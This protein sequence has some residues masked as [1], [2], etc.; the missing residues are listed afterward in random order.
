MYLITFFLNLGPIFELQRQ[1]DAL[2]LN[3]GDAMFVEAIITDSNSAGWNKRAVKP[4]HR[5]IYINGGA[6][7]P[8]CLKRF[9]FRPLKRLACLH[10]IGINLL[11][12]LNNNGLEC[13]ADIICEATTTGDQMAVFVLPENVPNQCREIV[14]DIFRDI[15]IGTLDSLITHGTFWI[16]ARRVSPSCP[17]ERAAIIGAENVLEDDAN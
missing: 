12:Y 11:T 14:T 17:V 2:R 9:P 4:G 16:D 5:N 3:P 13:F 10:A 8:Y 6:A 1:D 7:H 15:P